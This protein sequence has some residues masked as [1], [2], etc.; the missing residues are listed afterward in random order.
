VAATS[1]GSEEDGDD[2]RDDG[3]D[4]E[5]QTDRSVPATPG[6]AA[7]DLFALEPGFLATLGLRWTP[8]VVLTSCH[9]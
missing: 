9:V 2:D 4:D 5:A 6:H 7:L 1:T 8:V 3:N